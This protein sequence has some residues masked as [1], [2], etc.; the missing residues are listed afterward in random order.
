MN[1][2]LAASSSC[3]ACKHLHYTHLYSYMSLTDALLSSLLDSLVVQIMSLANSWRCWI[4]TLPPTHKMSATYPGVVCRPIL[5]IYSGSPTVSLASIQRE[6]IEMEST[7]L[8]KLFGASYSATALSHRSSALV[9]QITL[10]LKMANSN[11]CLIVTST[12]QSL[13]TMSHVQRSHT[14]LTIC[15]RAHNSLTLLC[16]RVNKK[17]GNLKCN[18]G[19]A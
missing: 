13:Y 16:I 11:L 2:L 5:L 7:T 8:V 1:K 3:R 10:T 12:A 19:I 17:L 15:M 14:Y 9:T 6:S 18:I 4:V